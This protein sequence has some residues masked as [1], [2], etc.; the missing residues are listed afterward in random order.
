MAT[1][2]RLGCDK[3]RLERDSCARKRC[4]MQGTPAVGAQR[5]ADSN[6]VLAAAG[7]CEVPD[8]GRRG[9][10]VDQTIVVG[11]IGW[12]L[13][14]AGAGEVGR[15]CNWNAIDSAKAAGDEA[16]VCQPADA[17]HDIKAGCDN[18][19]PGVIEIEVD[20]DLGVSPE[21]FG[22]QWRDVGA[23]E[24][25]RS[26]KAD[27]AGWRCACLAK[28]FLHCLRR[29]DERLGLRQCLVA[30][31]RKGKTARGAV[32]ERCAQTAFEAGD[33]AGDGGNRKPA[34]AGGTGEAA[35]LRDSGEEIPGFEIGNSHFLQGCL[36]SVALF[37]C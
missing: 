5:S 18:I 9:I 17:E 8:I 7:A 29:G 35:A 3:I 21:E 10:G 37:Y 30:K 28:A 2:Q 11:K 26:G 23:A 31:G 1:G 25:E 34:R 32:E 14:C 13:R 22:K 4:R 20:R 36:S 33:C 6:A 12:M 24:F 15:A 27:V 16:A 19:D